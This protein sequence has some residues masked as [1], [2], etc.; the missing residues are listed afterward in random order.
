MICFMVFA[1]ALYEFTVFL[2]EVAD[3][4]TVDDILRELNDECLALAVSALYI[5]LAIHLLK[6]PVRNGKP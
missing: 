4:A 3:R 1:A 6:E 5:E 2:L